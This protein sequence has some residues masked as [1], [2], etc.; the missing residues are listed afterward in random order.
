MATDRVS[1]RRDNLPTI[2]AWEEMLPKA[3]NLLNNRRKASRPEQ[4]GD[5]GRPRIPVSSLVREV[6]DPLLVGPLASR[7]WKAVAA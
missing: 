6:R 4:I 5:S 3:R 1:L 2:V 7:E